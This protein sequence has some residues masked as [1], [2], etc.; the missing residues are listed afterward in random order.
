MSCSIYD[1]V[2]L[3][4]MLQ[5]SIYTVVAINAI[6]ASFYPDIEHTRQLRFKKHNLTRYTKHFRQYITSDA[7]QV[8]GYIYR[9]VTSG[10]RAARPVFFLTL[11]KF[12]Y[13]ASAF[14]GVSRF[15]F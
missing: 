7:S 3:A 13:V 10:L 6:A 11:V 2:T 14:L 8:H 12:N 4:W 1:I 15:L 9:C 5:S